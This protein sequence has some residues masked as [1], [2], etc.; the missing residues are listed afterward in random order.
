MPVRV[1]HM[2]N[3]QGEM[4]GTSRP[5]ATQAACQEKTDKKKKQKADF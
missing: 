3:C 2:S 1:V 5:A 4:R